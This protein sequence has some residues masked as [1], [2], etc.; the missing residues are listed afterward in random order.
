MYTCT[1]PDEVKRNSEF[2]YMYNTE[3]GK[4]NSEIHVHLHVPTFWT[5]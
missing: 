3:L 5:P 2:G 1:N 4:R